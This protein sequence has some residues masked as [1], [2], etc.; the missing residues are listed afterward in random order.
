[1]GRVLTMRICTY[2]LNNKVVGF[3]NK[4]KESYYAYYGKHNN[5]YLVHKGNTIEECNKELDEYFNFKFGL[6]DTVNIKLCY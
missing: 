5:A 3:I 4:D 1:M 6:F 2:K